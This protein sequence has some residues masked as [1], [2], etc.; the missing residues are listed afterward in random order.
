MEAWWA[1]KRQTLVIVSTLEAASEL[2]GGAKFMVSSQSEVPIDGWPYEE[3]IER[4]SAD[5]TPTVAAALVLTALMRRRKSSPRQT[6]RA[7]PA[8]AAAK[9][10]SS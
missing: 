1:L 9:P 10:P 5:D 4:L 6:A 2:R 8:L 3:M 7:A